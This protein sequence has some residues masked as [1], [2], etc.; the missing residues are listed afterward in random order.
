MEILSKNLDLYSSQYESNIIIGDFNVGV[1][2]LYLKY[3]RN[4]HNLRSLIKESTFYKNPENPSCI[5]LILT[6]S[7]LSFQG[8]CVVETGLSDFHRMVVTIMKTAFQKLPPK[9]RTYRNYNKF[10]N[11]KFQETVVKESLTN[12][13]NNDVSNFIDI[14]M[15]SLDKHAPF[16][17]KSIRGNHLP[18]MNKELSKAIM[19]RS[20]LRNKFLRHGPN[21]NKKKY[22][23]QQNYC[24][25][26]LRRIKENCFSNPNEKNITN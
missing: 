19:H 7:H 12:T 4:A 24:V 1:S 5:D 26:L 3:F 18:F 11:R 22:S 13:W 6:N 2:D 9:I 21:E 17:K 16:E 8:S 15:R 23:K 20:K 10:Y 14:S 25:S